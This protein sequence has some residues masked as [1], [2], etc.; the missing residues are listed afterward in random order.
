[1]GLAVWR[2]VVGYEGLY[3]V[4]SD[5]RVKSLFRYKKELK[6]S[7]TNSGYYQIELFKNK[8]S[9]RYSVHRLVAQAF[10]PN[11]NNLP[12]VNHKDEIKTNNKV[13]NLE[14]CSYKYNQNYGTCIQRRVESI[15]YS[16]FER[17]EIARRNGK[18]CNKLIFQFSKEGKYIQCFVSIKEAKTLNINASHISENAKGK[19]KTAGGFVWKYGRGNDLSA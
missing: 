11:P 9:K 18:K 17:K 10:L 19:R 16:T 4:S 3:M 8:T 12:C 14:W 1:M 15:D 5:G 2:D 7:L 13:E 6:L